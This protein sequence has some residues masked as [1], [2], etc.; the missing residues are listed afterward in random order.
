[1]KPRK[2]KQKK[3][4]KTTTNQT[5]QSQQ[6]TRNTSETKEETPKDKKM[7]FLNTFQNIYSDPSFSNSVNNLIGYIK[8]EQARKNIFDYTGENITDFDSVAAYSEAV[9]DFEKAYQTTDVIQ[10]TPQKQKRTIA[11]LSI[12]AFMF[13][14]FIG[15]FEGL[16]TNKKRR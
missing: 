3:T 14:A 6:Q 4:T 8:T 16:G 7:L 11:G 10:I 13:A 9:Q 15:I 1:M 5:P 12:P 2:T